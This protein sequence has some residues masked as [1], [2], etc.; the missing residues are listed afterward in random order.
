VILVGGPKQ[1]GEAKFLM[2]P[3][4]WFASVPQDAT[5]WEKL[6]RQALKDAEAKLL[7]LNSLDGT[8]PTRIA[9]AKAAVRWNELLLESIKEDHENPDGADYGL[10]RYILVSQI[11]AAKMASTGIVP[12]G[13]RY[14]WLASSMEGAAV[15]ELKRALASGAVLPFRS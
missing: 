2:E 10:P 14:R 1:D 8:S 6:T 13:G 15:S 11:A 7:A 4:Y 12:Y 3:R 5:S 9:S